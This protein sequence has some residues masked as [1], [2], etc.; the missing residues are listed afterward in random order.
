MTNKWIKLTSDN[1]ILLNTIENM[2]ENKIPHEHIVIYMTL[3]WQI[4]KDA[5]KSLFIPINDKLSVFYIPITESLLVAVLNNQNHRRFDN[6]TIENAIISFSN[7]NLM[8]EQDE[9]GNL[10]KWEA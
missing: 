6:T 10:H 3:C 8:Y 1:E 4:I 5:K 9:N 7:M 2:L